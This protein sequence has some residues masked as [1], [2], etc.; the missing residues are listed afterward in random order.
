MKAI[1]YKMRCCRGI[2][3]QS[4]GMYITIDELFIPEL[5]LRINIEGAVNIYSEKEPR[6]NDKSKEIELDNS[7]KETITSYLESKKLIETTIKKAFT[8][9]KKQKSIKRESV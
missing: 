6:S 8:N 5:K 2:L 4:H 7:F 1:K 3:E 9:V